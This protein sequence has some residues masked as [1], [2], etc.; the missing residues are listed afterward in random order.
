MKSFQINIYH[1]D[2]SRFKCTVFKILFAQRGIFDFGKAIRFFRNNIHH[3]FKFPVPIQVVVSTDG[4]FLIHRQGNFDGDFIFVFDRKFSTEGT[5][6]LFPVMGK[7]I[8][9]F[10]TDQGIFDLALGFLD[11]MESD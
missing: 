10:F 7:R 6:F 5:V 8:S 11:S 4:K 1:A 9:I 2:F 3:Q